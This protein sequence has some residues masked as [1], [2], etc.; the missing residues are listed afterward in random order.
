M[1]SLPIDAG[2]LAGSG[3]GLPG[4]GMRKSVQ[5]DISGCTSGHSVSS[6]CVREEPSLATRPGRRKYCAL[7]GRRRQARNA[8]CKIKKAITS[9]GTRP[10]VFRPI[11][12]PAA[13]RQV[14]LPG[15]VLGLAQL[16]VLKRQKGEN[17]RE[18][19]EQP[20]QDL[21]CLGAIA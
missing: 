8:A 14:S 20:P 15:L 21:I 11:Q 5:V 7:A 9:E 17:K 13:K 12:L 4:A 19:Q 18:H 16:L 10:E 1:S 6:R 2:W 3:P